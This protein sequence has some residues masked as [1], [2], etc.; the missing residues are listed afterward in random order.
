M[1]SILV[2]FLRHTKKSTTRKI[3]KREYR[4]LDD[5]FREQESRF[6]SLLGS[7]NKILTKI[8]GLFTKRYVFMIPLYQLISSPVKIM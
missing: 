3:M 7:E 5:V 1:L 4:G 2:S 8:T 6:P